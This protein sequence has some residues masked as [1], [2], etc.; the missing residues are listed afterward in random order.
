MNTILKKDSW[1]NKFMPDV[2]GLSHKMYFS[3]SMNMKIGYAIYLPPDYS[4]KPSNNNFSKKNYPVIYWL[5][6][7]GGD[8]ASGFRVNIPAIFHK[9]IIE[10]SI[11]SAIMVYVQVR[12]NCI[13]K[14]IVFTIVIG[15]GLAAWDNDKGKELLIVIRP[16]YISD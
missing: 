7:K 12:D 5:H 11:E 6:G 2:P 9:A 3:K 10:G 13:D 15:N 4:F 14:R 16:M 1:I 8:E